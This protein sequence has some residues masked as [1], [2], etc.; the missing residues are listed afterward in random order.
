MSEVL[1]GIPMEYEPL[2]PN[3]FRLKFPSELGIQE[4]T[5]A[6]SGG[7]QVDQNAV[8]I[9]YFNTS[10]WVAGRYT[11]GTMNFTLLDLIGPS[12]KQAVMEWFRLHAESMT[13]RQGYAI[14]YKKTIVLEETDPTGV[15]VSKWLLIDCQ[16]TNITFGDKSYDD[17]SVQQID[18]TV[19]P[20]YC[21]LAY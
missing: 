19:Q 15:A 11:W 1:R 6:A 16:I 20:F 3:R 14:G 7:P 8:E 4:W 5:V 17:D 18:I 13:G 2:R 9:P 21:L 10:T 12:T